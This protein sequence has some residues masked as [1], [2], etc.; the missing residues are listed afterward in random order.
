MTTTQ[1]TLLELAKFND[2]LKNFFF[3]DEYN[4]N[5]TIELSF[6][7]WIQSYGECIIVKENKWY[8]TMTN[9]FWKWHRDIEFYEILIDFILSKWQNNL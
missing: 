6:W 1:T 7:V 9:S 5:N 4:Q 8:C 3:V 2:K